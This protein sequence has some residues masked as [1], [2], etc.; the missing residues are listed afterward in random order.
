MSV[1]KLRQIKLMCSLEEFDV[2]EIIEIERLD[3]C[4]FMF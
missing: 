2:L 4:S 1:E 3:R